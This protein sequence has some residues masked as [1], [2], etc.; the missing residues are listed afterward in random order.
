M[1]FKVNITTDNSAFEGS[2]W[3][4]EVARIL[5]TLAGQLDEVGRATHVAPEILIRDINGNTVGEA[6]VTS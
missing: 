4:G 1:K 5:R 2:C 6:K 3:S